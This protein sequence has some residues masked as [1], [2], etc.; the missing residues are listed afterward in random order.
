MFRPCIDLHQGKVKQIVGGTL[1]D[2]GE[3]LQTNFVSERGA[4]YFAEM[5]RKDGLRGGHVIKLGSGNDE[6]AREALAAYPGGLQ[7]GGGIT[8]DN[9]EEWLKAGASHVIVTS[10]IFRDG[11]LCWERLREIERRVGKERLVLD[12]SCRKRDGRYWVVTDRWQRF[13]EEAIDRRTLERLGEHCAEFLVH[14]A[15]VE[16]RCQG[17]E[18]ELVRELGDWGMVPTTYAGGGRGLED[19]ERVERLGDGRV[20]LT[21]GS[22]LDI[23]G[24]S[25]VRY[26]DVVAWNKAHPRQEP[27]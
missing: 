1:K 4:A 7:I 2:S 12:L 20:D 16:G 25:G 5:Y 9:A 14:A 3:G 11:R 8:A 13:T 18:E 26:S 19:L 21:L 15:D 24:G 23:F 22:A 17:I 6:A 10:Y 27:I